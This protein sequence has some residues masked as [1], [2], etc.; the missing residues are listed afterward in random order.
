MARSADLAY[1]LVRE[2]IVQGAL[3]PGDALGEAELAASI[4]VS[5]TPVRDALRRLQAEGLVS[6][7]PNHGARVSD[8]SDDVADVYELRMLLEGHAARRAASRL[9]PG[10]LDRLE[11]LCAEMEAEWAAAGDGHVDRIT[12]LNS[13]FH[14]VILNAASSSRLSALTAT[15]VELPLVLRTFSQYGR[16]D[17]ERSLGHHRELVDSFRARDPA[18]AESVMRSHIAAARAVLLAEAPDEAGAPAGAP[19]RS[20]G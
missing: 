8:W 5:R 14:R 11:R 16:R 2:R 12:E 13:T 17:L 1:R 18:W 9:V 4:G 20:A 10:D 15:V 7:E 19:R 6:R 3:A